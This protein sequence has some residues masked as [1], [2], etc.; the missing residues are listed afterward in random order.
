MSALT[1]DRTP[2]AVGMPAGRTRETSMLAACF[3]DSEGSRF[4]AAAL[5][6]ST[7]C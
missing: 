4:G 6:S 5:R 7:R 3:A 2:D 1:R